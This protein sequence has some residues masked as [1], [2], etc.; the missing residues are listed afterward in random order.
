M[1]KHLKYSLVVTALLYLLAS[2]IAWDIKCITRLPEL[3]FEGRVM[4][5]TLFIAKEIF[6]GLA[7]KTKIKL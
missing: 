2:F 6:I 1:K 4:I 3:P 7:L 5:A